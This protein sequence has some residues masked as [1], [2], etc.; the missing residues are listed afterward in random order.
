MNTKTDKTLLILTALFVGGLAVVAGAISF[1]HM[2][3]LATHHD[4]TGWK[5]YAFPISVDGLEIVA[6]LYLV[7]QRRAGRPTGWVPWVALIVGTA[8]SLAANVAVGGADPVGKALAGWPALSMLVSVKLLFAMLDHETR[9]DQ[10]TIVRDDQQTVRDDQRTSGT[11]PADPE[12]VRR[13]GRDDAAPSATV[14]A[15]RSADTPTTTAPGGSGHPG[16]P[17]APIDVRTVAHL[18]PAARAARATLAE[19]GLSLS[20]DHLADVMRDEGHGVSNE[21][22]SLLL[23]ML[24]AEQDVTAIEPGTIPPRSQEPET[25]TEVVA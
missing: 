17:A 7:A 1:D 9:D 16:G 25:L 20:R 2:R 14:P 3:E 15:D 8:A 11:V 13:S 19:T 5:S 24:K 18:I 4:Q 22:A 23:K 12:I 10:R 6:S 21:R